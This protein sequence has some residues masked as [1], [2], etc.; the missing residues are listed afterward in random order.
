MLPVHGYVLA[1][2]KSSRMGCDKA[3]L[4]FQ[5]RPLAEIAVGKLREFCSEVSIA[6]NREDLA[7]FATV[8]REE[9]LEVGP[10]AGLE[11]GLMASKRAWS[12]FLPVDVPLLPA[13]LLQK[14]AEVVLLREASGCRLSSLRAAGRLHPAICLLHRDCLSAVKLALERGVHKL[15]R[16]FDLIRIELGADAL[17][18]RDAESLP[19]SSVDGPGQWTQWFSNL[20]TPEDVAA[21]ERDAEA[22]E[23]A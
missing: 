23:V 4:P 1:G 2:G 9:S 5:G 3:L 16:V 21:A 8:V 19:L 13:T 12:L 18:I 11:S 17:C 14:W 10:V 22:S 15:E 7:R 6:G 20:N